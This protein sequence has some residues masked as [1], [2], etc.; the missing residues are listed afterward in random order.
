MNPQHHE[1]VRAHPCGGQGL[2]LATAGQ[3]EANTFNRRHPLERV[4]PGPPGHEIAG[5]DR[6]RRKLREL[7]FA[8][9]DEAVGLGKGQRPQQHGVDDAEDR[10]R[11]PHPQGERQHG[12]GRE[13][14]RPP[15]PSIGDAQAV[16]HHS[17]TGST[18]GTRAP[19][20][21][22]DPRAFRWR[23]DWNRKGLGAAGALMTSP[24]RSASRRPRM[25]RSD[26]PVDHDRVLSVSAI[27]GSRVDS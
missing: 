27:S 15:E 1:Q 23:T 3:V 21:G 10:R 6:K 25:I 8:E 26:H 14:L 9:D 11:R 16:P 19:V 18:P 24:A 20:L 2:G 4:V 5:R 17:S 12:N 22:R 13:R 7:R